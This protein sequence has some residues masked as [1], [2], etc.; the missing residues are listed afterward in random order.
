MLGTDLFRSSRLMFVPPIMCF[1]RLVDCFYLPS[2]CR[3]ELLLRMTSSPALPSTEVRCFC[4][5]E[6]G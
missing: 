6:L 5:E 3:F 4:L 1:D 2:I